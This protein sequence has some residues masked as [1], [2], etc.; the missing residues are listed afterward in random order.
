M[1][2]S[3]QTIIAATIAAAALPAIDATALSPE[4]YVPNSVMAQGKWVKIK[5]SGHGMHI[6][7]DAQLRQMGFP[8]PQDVHVF[9][10]GG[11]HLGNALTEDNHDDL[12]LL[13][14]VRTSKGTVFYATDH[15]TWQTADKEKPYSHTIHPY[16]DETYYF[17]SDAPVSGNAMRKAT[18]VAAAAP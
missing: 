13:P 4:H 10:L 2:K 15:N 5:T 12:P 14:S 1:K 8:N 18:T 11:R 6:V 3:R 7:T 16:C 17:L 9:G